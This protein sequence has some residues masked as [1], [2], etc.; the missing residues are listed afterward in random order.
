MSA[1]YRARS[2]K[3]G[4]PHNDSHF[5]GAK[6]P[7]DMQDA[8]RHRG[9][10]FRTINC[11]REPLKVPR[12]CGSNFPRCQSRFRLQ[13]QQWHRGTNDWK[14]MKDILTDHVLGIMANTVDDLETVRTA[15]DNRLRA[16]T[17]EHGLDLNHPDVARTAA[18]A[19]TM[20]S[21]EHQAILNMNRAVRRHPLWQW[22]KPIT[23]VGEKQFAR[24]L[25][26][27]GDPYWNYLH[28]RPRTMRELRAYCGWH[29]IDSN[30]DKDISDSKIIAVGVAPKRQRGQQ[31]NWNDEARKRIWLIAESCMKQRKSIYRDV[32]DAARK[33]YLDS[34]HPT[35]CVRCGP[36]GKPAQPGSIRSD[37]HQHAMALRKVAVAFLAD[38]WRESKRLHET[39]HQPSSSAKSKL[40]TG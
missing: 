7:Y 23:G 9:P 16:L 10:N 33:Q 26:V 21:L 31:S 20:R 1:S 39:S 32:Y 11:S 25:A 22:A 35:A 38:L 15:T 18:I 30:A 3:A 5:H 37:G 34:V 19:E 8:F 17:S 14:E 13:A 12:L 40:R 36:K 4:S 2:L 29:V 6:A 27:I 24:L 28:D